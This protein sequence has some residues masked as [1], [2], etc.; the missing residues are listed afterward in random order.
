MKKQFS[1]I[2]WIYMYIRERHTPWD[3][4]CDVLSLNYWVLYWKRIKQYVK[5]TLIVTTKFLT[6]SSNE[7]D[8]ST[9]RGLLLSCWVTLPMSRNKSSIERHSWAPS[10]LGCGAPLISGLGSPSSAPEAAVQVLEGRPCTCQRPSAM[11]LLWK[12][13][14]SCLSIYTYIYI[15]I[16]QTV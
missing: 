15:L 11:S 9:A 16:L 10:Q 7:C 3:A 14:K 12:Y 13:F 8:I 4:Y 6:L 2:E 1:L 5:A